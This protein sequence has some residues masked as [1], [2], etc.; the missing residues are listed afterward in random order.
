MSE[1]TRWE[2][3]Y[4]AFETPAEERR[5]FIRRL[6]SVGAGGWSRDARVL[7]VCSGRGNGLAAWREL[8]FAR[9]YGVDLSRSLV[10]VSALRERCAVG[11]ACRLPIRPASIDVAIIQGGLHHFPTFDL[12]R[13][14][15]AEMR[16]VLAPGGRVVIV[17][18]ARTPF[19][20]AVHAISELK[21]VR[22][23]SGRMDAFATM[24]EEEYP[25]YH[26]WIERTDEVLRTIRQE[27]DQVWLRRRWGKLVFVGRPRR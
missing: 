4:Q 10:E 25:L 15:L 8:G 18:P 7:E 17:E 13:A 23:L 19:L 20:T 24:T 26:A 2:R 14:G 22:A 21:P 5:K 9:V 3:A 1:L 11:D 6:R 12:V 27:F 16:R